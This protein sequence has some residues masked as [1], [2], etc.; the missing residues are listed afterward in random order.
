VVAEGVSD[1]KPVDG[2]GTRCDFGGFFGLETF[3]S[4]FLDGHFDSGT[5]AIV[6][7]V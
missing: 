4:E 7:A 6:C 5:Y 1:E 2:G 3:G